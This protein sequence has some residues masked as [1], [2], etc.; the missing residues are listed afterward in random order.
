MNC[1]AMQKCI[2]GK[3][4]RG[5]PDRDAAEAELWRWLPTG[6]DDFAREEEN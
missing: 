5:Q 4:H 3:R 6:F 2:V 1:R